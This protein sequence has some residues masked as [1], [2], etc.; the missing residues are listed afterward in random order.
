MRRRCRHRQHRRSDHPSRPSLDGRVDLR[1]RPPTRT[2][3]RTG[4]RLDLLITKPFVAVTSR[5]AAFFVYVGML[6]PLLP[7][8][9][10]DELGAGELGVGLSDRHVRPGGDRRPT[11]HRPTDRAVRPAGRD[12]RR[13][14]DRGGG[15]RADRHRR[16]ARTA[17]RPARRRRHR[18]GSRCSSPPPRSS[19]TSPRPTGGPRPPA[20]SPSP[21]SPGSASGPIVGE[22]VLTATIIHAAFAVAAAVPRPRR[23]AGVGRPDAVTAIHRPRH[24]GAERDAGCDRVIHPAA[25][26][27]GF[28]LASGIGCVRRLL[29]VPARPRP[30]RR[31]CRV[32]RPV[33]GLQRRVPRSA[34]HGRPP[35]RAAR[36]PPCRHDRPDA[37]RPLRWPSWP[38]SRTRG[39]CGQRP[40]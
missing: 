9:I 11:G 5:P 29:G 33:R 18:R 34:R 20:T 22:L 8:F 12:H 24:A 15:R 39:R 6:V 10:E 28:V 27:P 23:R 35:A 25:V 17:A 4:R 37:A 26:G 30:L 40:W 21:C 1:R 13:R 19:P 32:G 31:P 2:V 38:P 3:T 14:A 36:G 16:L 7:T